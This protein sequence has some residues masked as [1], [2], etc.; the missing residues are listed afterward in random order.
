MNNILPRRS[1]RLLQSKFGDSTGKPNAL[2]YFSRVCSCVAAN[3]MRP[4]P[5][6]KFCVYGNIYDKV[7][8]EILMTQTAMKLDRSTNERMYNL[9][10]GGARITIYKY[11]IDN[12]EY[13]AYK[14]LAQYD[15]IVVPTDIR[16]NTSIN[17]YKKKDSLLNFNVTEVESVSSIENNKTEDIVYEKGVDFEVELTPAITKIIWKDGGKHPTS[18]YTVRYFSS[19]NFI[20]WEDHPKKRGAADGEDPRVVYCRLRPYYD[21]RTSPWLD[22]KTDPPLINYVG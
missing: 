9:Y 13:R 19:V 15:V 20:V 7:P 3:E 6:C 2:I 10:M 1:Q 14:S 12:V 16:V 21:P 11:G 5:K 4:D 17:I 18:H 8:E 22:V